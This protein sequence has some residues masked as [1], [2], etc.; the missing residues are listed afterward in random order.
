MKLV[1]YRRVSTA[2]QS[3]EGFGL[4]VQSD[5]LRVGALHL[6]ATLIATF[7]DA[8]E[9]GA[10]GVESRLALHEALAMIARGEVDGILVPR[11][12]RLARDLILQEQLIKEIRRLGGQVFSCAG[13]EDGVLRGDDVDPSRQLIRQ[14]LGA[15]AAYERAMIRLRL[16]AGRARKRAGGGYAGHGPPAYGQV[17]VEGELMPEPREAATIRRMRELSTTMT[18]KEVAATLNAEGHKA[19]RGGSWYAESVRRTLRRA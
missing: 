14:V 18:L 10:N 5:L 17:A 12:D 4:D 13:G 6:G 19:K 2:L 8:G 11:L 15:V 9:S 1:G 16:E 3:E 7:T